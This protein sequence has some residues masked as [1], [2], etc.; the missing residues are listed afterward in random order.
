LVLDHFSRRAMGFAVF[1]TPPTSEAVRALLGRAIRSAKATPQHLVYD[2]GP[3]F[4]NGGF[5]AWCRCRG[6]RPR[7]GAIGQHGSIAV[8]ERLIRTMKELLRLRLPLI[9]LRREPFRREVALALGWYNAH[10][11]HTSLGGRTPEE[12]YF[13]L[14]PA[15]RSPRFE[16]RS[17][18]PRGSPC[19]SPWALV[20]GKPG[21]KV[22]L[23]V[24]FHGGGKSLPVVRLSRAA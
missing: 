21:A 4:W 19:A 9:P 18:W 22:E 6:I 2:K 13:R 1:R 7:F 12:V 14:R 8:I 10:R 15:N 3:Q 11:P 20:K 5:K 23:D 24:R 16:P 17:R